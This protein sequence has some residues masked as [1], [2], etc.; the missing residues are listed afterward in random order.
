VPFL[1]QGEQQ[2]E[3]RPILALRV[4]PDPRFPGNMTDNQQIKRIAIVGGGT[5]G[6]MAASILARAL[7]GTHTVITVIESPDIGTVGVGEATIPPII[8]LLKFLSINEGD[9]VKHT[10]ATYKLG[11]KF[12]D[13]AREGHSYWHPFG[14]FGAMINLRP[15]PHAWARAQAQGLAP[16]FND[17]SLCAALGDAG[18]FRFPDAAVPGPVAGLRYALHFDAGLVAQYLRAYSERL[19]VARMERTVADTTLRENGFIDELV[20]SDGARLQADLYIDCSGFRGVLI[21]GAL[22]T[23]YLEW[24]DVLPCDRA[25]AMPT[26]LVRPRPPYTEAISHSAGWRW[27]IPLQHRVGNGYVY[28]SAYI[29]DTQALDELTAAVGAKP[30]AEPRFLRFVTGRRKVFWNRNCVALGLASGFL[31]PLESTSI[32]LV[33]SGLYK[34]LEHFPNTSFAQSNI[35]SYNTELIQEIERIRD[36]IVLHYLAGRVDTPLWAYC[37][38]MNLPDS[39]V[40]RI[41]LYERTG[42]IRTKIGELFTDLSWFYIF[43]GIGIKPESYDPLLDVVTM[44]QLREILGSMAQATAVAA[45]GVPSHDSYFS[46]GNSSR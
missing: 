9:F 8:D 4:L 32:H 11:I 40:Q 25:V 12:T 33:M 20:F 35:D 13:W 36:F 14:S 10:Q 46:A 5:A 30:L 7:P 1:L 34:L 45:H 42:R 17:F 21:E 6:W 39:L 26:E 16:R 3:N 41:E 44:P 15:F 23:G 2:C 24:S 19:G 27:R 43:E 22:K 38:K 29:S 18:K 37:Q 28:S 31:E